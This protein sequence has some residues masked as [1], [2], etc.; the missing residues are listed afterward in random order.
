MLRAPLKKGD[1]YE[2]HIAY[3]LALVHST[4]RL[5]LQSEL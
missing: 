1:F 4:F 2:I 3:W 5:N